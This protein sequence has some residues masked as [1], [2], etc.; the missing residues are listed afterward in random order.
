MLSGVRTGA[1]PPCSTGMSCFY[2]G[3]CLVPFAWWDPL[4]RS[5]VEPLHPIPA[6]PA[7]LALHPVPLG[8]LFPV[9]RC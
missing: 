8:I 2:L 3:L 7:E 5:V 4:P 1:L 6:L 9:T